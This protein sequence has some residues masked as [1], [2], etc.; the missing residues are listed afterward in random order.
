MYAPPI[1]AGLYNYSINGLEALRRLR[2]DAAVIE[3]DLV[4]VQKR[5]GLNGD[6]EGAKLLKHEIKSLQRQQKAASLWI[7]WFEAKA[8]LRFKDWPEELKD[9]L[10][11]ALAIYQLA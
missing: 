2:R 8:D 1:H 11:T 7:D 3:G 6:R 4:A 10:D 5:I 9:E